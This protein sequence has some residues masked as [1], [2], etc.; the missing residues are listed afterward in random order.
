MP[1]IVTKDEVDD[2]EDISGTIQDPKRK[3][4]DLIPNDTSDNGE[5]EEYDP[6]DAESDE[7]LDIVASDSEDEF[8]VVEE[9]GQSE[10]NGATRK[11]YKSYRR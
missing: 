3:H 1:K 7:I 2:F 11:W 10:H 4:K 5:V 8:E 6:V 9:L